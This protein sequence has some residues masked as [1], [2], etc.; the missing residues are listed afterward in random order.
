MGQPGWSWRGLIVA[1][2][3]R[4]QANLLRYYF[5]YPERRSDRDFLLSGCCSRSLRNQRFGSPDRIREEIAQR[6]SAMREEEEALQWF[7]DDYNARPYLYEKDGFGGR[8]NE[9]AIFSGIILAPRRT[10]A[11]RKPGRAPAWASD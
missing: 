4:N 2:K 1:G 11:R 10:R 9:R 8:G 6:R 7:T 3:V 5:K